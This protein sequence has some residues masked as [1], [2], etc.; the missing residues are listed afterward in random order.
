MLKNLALITMSFVFNTAFAT[1]DINLHHAA[2]SSLNEYQLVGKQHFS[3]SMTSSIIAKNNNLLKEVNVTRQQSKT[4]TRYQQ[5]YQ[6]IPVFGAQVMVRQNQYQGFGSNSGSE[7]NGHL[8]KEINLDTN[9]AFDTNEAIVL[10]KQAW[11]NSTAQTPTHQVKAELQ[12][13][14]GQDNV[15]QLVY[16]ISFKTFDRATHEPSWPHLLVNAKTGE[17]INQ[18]NNINHYTDTGP[19]GNEK[20]HEY[21]YGLDGLPGLDVIQQDAQ[22]LMDDGKVKLVDLKTVMDWEDKIVTPFQYSCGNNVEEPTNHA[23]S[24]RNDAWVF[25]HVIVD[26]YRNWYELSALQT[27]SGE[28]APLVMR[29]HFGQDYN[30]AFW[31]GTSMNFGDGDGYNFYPLVSLDVA[32]HEVTHGFT[33]QHADLEYH[34]QSG[35]LNESMSDMA[36]VTAQ[37]YLLE[38]SPFLYNKTNITPDIISWKIGES[39]I[40]EGSIIGMEALR[41]MNAPSKDRVSADCLDKELA[42]KNGGICAVSYDDVVIL[43]KIFAGKD[44]NLLQGIIVHYA[45]GIFNKA[46]YLISKKLGIKTAYLIMTQANINYWTPDTDFIKGAC[47]VIHAANDLKLDINPV[48]AALGK[49]G[50]D[51]SSCIL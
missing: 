19:G 9:P 13:R 32:S 39:I 12:I 46:F 31:N 22:C 45:S 34:D 2:I 40:P 20:T 27:D 8:L 35:A 43:A 49:V 25:G 16:L 38:T 15:L 3:Q 18:W 11:F 50:I 48:N 51:I 28:S 5:I 24:P 26:M 21:W 17:I 47:G 33:Q 4:I 29:V 14:S 30:N 1:I 10:A 23:F 37:A 42:R 36:G 44:E 41:F 6:G 7:V